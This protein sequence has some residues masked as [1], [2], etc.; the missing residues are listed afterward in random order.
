MKFKNSGTE[1]KKIPKASRESRTKK[2]HIKKK[3]VKWLELLK[4][5]Q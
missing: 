1:G 3:Y 4:T 5:K 2:D